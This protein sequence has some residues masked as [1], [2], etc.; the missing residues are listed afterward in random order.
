MPSVLSEVARPGDVF[1]AEFRTDRDAHLAKIHGADYRRYQ[2][3]QK[4]ALVLTDRCHFAVVVEQEGN[5]FS[6][7]N[8]EDPY[9]YRVIA[10]RPTAE[11]VAE[12]AKVEALAIEQARLLAARSREQPPA[13]ATAPLP[14]QRPSA[15]GSHARS[16]ATTPRL[17]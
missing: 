11:E 8:G 2:S 16:R 3:A 12:A 14:R 6:P 17:P 10:R 13:R 9:L 1:A 5:G 15:T 7:Y 4:F